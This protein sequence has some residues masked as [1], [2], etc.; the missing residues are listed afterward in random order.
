MLFKNTAKNSLKSL[1]TKRVHSLFSGVPFTSAPAI[2]A[3][4]KTLLRTEKPYSGYFSQFAIRK[5]N[6]KLAEISQ[7][8]IRFNKRRAMDVQINFKSIPE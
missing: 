5:K 7:F 1:K 2:E 3:S 8:P 4:Q 6:F